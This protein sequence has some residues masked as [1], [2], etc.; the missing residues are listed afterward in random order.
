MKKPKVKSWCTEAKMKRKPKFRV[1][2]VVRYRT[3]GKVHGTIR[4]Y[5]TSEDG[6]LWVLLPKGR[7]RLWNASDL[8]LVRR[9][10]KKGKKR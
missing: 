9:A 7:L 4:N 10:K 3:A 1:G 5:I 8:I 2:D 6:F